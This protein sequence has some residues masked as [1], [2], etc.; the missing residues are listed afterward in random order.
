M[1]EFDNHWEDR[2]ER[3]EARRQHRRHRGHDDFGPGFAMGAGF[4]PGFAAAGGAFGPSGAFGP[5]GPFGPGG[6]M[7]PRGRGRGRR[8]HV[9]QAILSLLLEE[10]LNGY[11]IMQTLADRTQGAWR[12]SPGAVY[13]ALA[14]LE[15]EGLIESFDNDGQKAFR[16]TD[17][18]SEQAEKAEKPWETV[19][20]ALAG[21]GNEQLGTMWREYAAL[22]GAAKELSRNGTTAQLEAAGKLI[23][24]ARR[25][26]YGLLAAEE[27]L[28]NAD[29]LR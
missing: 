28:P 24:D 11:Q 14:Q 1:T 16:L 18:G 19:N 23:A 12:P 15:D 29:D 25:R 9:R 26:L 22:G 5:G 6:A 13:P 4:G 10:P 2:D 8:G 21:M 3:R 17:E 7:G 20:Q 27:D